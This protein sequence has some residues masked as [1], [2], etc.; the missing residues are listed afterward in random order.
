MAR[1]G[2]H[3]DIQIY[4]PFHSELALLFMYCLYCYSCVRLSKLMPLSV[5]YFSYEKKAGVGLGQHFTIC[6]L[7]NTLIQNI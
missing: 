3:P 4:W 1:R 6:G 7:G 5:S 2:F